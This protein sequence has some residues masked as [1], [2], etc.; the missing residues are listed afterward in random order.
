MKNAIK[1]VIDKAKSNQKEV[2]NRLGLKQSTL[3]K[4]MNKEIQGTIEWSLEV[5]QEL[6]VKTYSIENENY[7]IKVTRK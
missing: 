7:K 4:R 3:S 5:A 2:C 6:G 1:E